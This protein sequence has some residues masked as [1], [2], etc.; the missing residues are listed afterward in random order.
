M[1]EGTKFRLYLLVVVCTLAVA[2]RLNAQTETV[3]YSF[4]GGSDGGVPYSGLV[5]DTEGNLYG[6]AQQYGNNSCAYSSSGCGTVFELQRTSAGWNYEVL[7]NF[8]GG[9]DGWQPASVLTLD[10]KGN[11]YGT[12]QFGGAA[13]SAG[14]GTVFELERT[15]SGWQESILYAFTGGADGGNPTA[16]LVFDAAGN[17]YGTTGA[18]GNPNCQGVG[19]GVVF[20]LTPSPDGWKEAVLHTFTGLDG[21]DPTE[22]V[23]LVPASGANPLLGP[24]GT[25]FGTTLYGGDSQLAYSGDGVVFQLIPSGGSYLY[26]TLYK[27]PSH[28]GNPGGPLIFDRSGSLY[29]MDGHGGSY[30][31]GAVFELSVSAS[32]PFGSWVERDIY[33]FYGPNGAFGLDQSVAMDKAGRLYGTTARGGTGSLCGDG[34]GTVFRLTK[35]AQGSWYESGLYSFPGGTGGWEL[36]SGVTL[37]QQGQLYGMTTTGGDLSCAGY[38]AGCGVVFQISP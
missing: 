6:T 7:Y 31:Y 11:L 34:C 30:G 17:I 25:I 33:P 35:T 22:G 8:Q 1:P 14:Y 37:D 13:D 10:S 28:L 19:C 12:T 2:E 24:P 3:L 18:H 9:S 5:M 21:S 15:P 38:E 23:T 16:G 32:Q 20:K 29:G 27:F 4:T 26:R 36:F